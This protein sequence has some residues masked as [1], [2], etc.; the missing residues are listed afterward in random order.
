MQGVDF[1]SILALLVRHGVEFVVVGG[2]AANLEGAP[3]MTYD[4]DIVHSTEPENA[5]RLL[6]ALGELDAVYRAQPS[7]R[8]RPGL[9]HVCSPGRQLL[10]TRFG[11][12]DALGAIGR[13]RVYLDLLQD[14]VEVPVGPDV[15]VRVLSL[16]RQIEI[17]QESG[18]EKDLAALPLLRHT[19]E[20][21]RRAQPS[22]DPS[23]PRR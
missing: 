13:G 12:L 17:K 16:E 5:A 11:P 10:A 21:R 7:R 8:L 18:G 14:S 3:M 2:V 9:S 4:L 6:S 19:L 20:E 15:T 1:R 22:P 23:G